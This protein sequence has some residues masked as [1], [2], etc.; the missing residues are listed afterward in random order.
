MLTTVV[1]NETLNDVNCKGF[2]S[3]AKSEES[4]REEEIK[5]NPSEKRVTNSKVISRRPEKTCL[6][7]NALFK[8]SPFCRMS[9]SKHHTKARTGS[10]PNDRTKATLKQN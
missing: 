2:V 8:G 4:Q 1:F 3:K 10:T 9:C 6:R 5:G 7:T